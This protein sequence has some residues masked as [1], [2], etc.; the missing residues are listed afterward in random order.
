M[1]KSTVFRPSE[2]FPR[3]E[4]KIHVNDGKNMFNQFTYP[5]SLMLKAHLKPIP[6]P[7]PAS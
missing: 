6:V 7:V 3:L 2:H 5:F 1:F 4:K